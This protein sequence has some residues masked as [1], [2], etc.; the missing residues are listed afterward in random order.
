MKTSHQLIKMHPEQF[1]AII[2]IMY[3]QLQL[4]AAAISS[5]G[6]KWAKYE[7]SVSSD[8]TTN[9]GTNKRIRQA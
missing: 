2:F 6:G 1:I 7:E 8:M 3:N 9:P 5:S 4:N